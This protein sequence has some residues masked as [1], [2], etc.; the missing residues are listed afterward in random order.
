MAALLTE[1]VAIPTIS[2]DPAHRQ[3][4]VRSAELIAA[5]LVTRNF[6]VVVADDGGALPTIIARRG[7]IP[8]SPT[9]LLYSH[10]DVQ[11]TGDVAAWSSD[12]FT[13]TRRGTVLYGRGSGDNKA[14]IVAH[15]AAIDA[16]DA[17]AA[18]DADAAH[19]PTHHPGIVVVIDGGEEI[20][21]PGFASVLANHLRDIDPE[22]IIVNDGI[23]FARGI[24]SLT[25]SL[26]GLLDVDVTVS[27]M[28]EPR[29]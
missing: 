28:D 16:V 7:V 6:E 13:A 5:Q 21:S 15:L 1:L 17:D 19:D 12:P 11:P 24:P 22:L 27:L 4:I 9:V 25:T 8:N 26:R 3:D 14:G 18:N 20:G 23:N 10:H 29:C 2:S